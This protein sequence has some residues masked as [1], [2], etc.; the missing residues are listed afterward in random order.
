MELGYSV[1]RSA[2][3]ARA[4]RGK[5]Q[6]RRLAIACVADGWAARASS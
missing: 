4:H 3:A 2:F 5:H 6:L 1:Y